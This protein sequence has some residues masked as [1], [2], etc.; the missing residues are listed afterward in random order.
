MLS[1]GCVDRNTSQS[2]ATIT[3]VCCAI[4]P[5]DVAA[6]LDMQELFM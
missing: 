5:P 2:R 6:V 1:S 4:F 3:H